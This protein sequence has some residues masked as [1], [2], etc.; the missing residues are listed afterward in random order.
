MSRKILI[1]GLSII[2]TLGIVGAATFAYFSDVAQ[3]TNNVFGAGT[4][5]LQ[6]NG[7]NENISSTFNL[8]SMSPGDT[9]AQVI[10]LHNA[11]TTDIAEVALGLTSTNND[12]DDPDNSDLRSV[13]LM[14]VVEGG[15]SIAGPNGTVCDGSGDVTNSVDGQ[16][17]DNSTP[18]TMTEFTGDTYNALAIP[19]LA[20]GADDQVCL[21]VGLDATNTTDIYQGDSANATFVFTAFQDISQ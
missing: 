2:A 11:G 1:S 21:E 3:S 6:L 5:N 18:L 19:L 17:G 20:G 13:L 15:T 9:A 7:T 14:K 4:M 8:P 12:P 16:V 10:S